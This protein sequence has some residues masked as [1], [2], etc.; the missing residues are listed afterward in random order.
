MRERE[1]QTDKDREKKEVSFFQKSNDKLKKSKIKIS[2]PL[3]LLCL[4]L[5]FS[6]WGGGGLG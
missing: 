3:K 1:M 6:V 5:N 2:F 4:L